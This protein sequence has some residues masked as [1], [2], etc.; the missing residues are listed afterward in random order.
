M[1]LLK[2]YVS[3]KQQKSEILL[4]SDSTGIGIRITIPYSNSYLVNQTDPKQKSNII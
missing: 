3:S 4:N 2:L 1:S